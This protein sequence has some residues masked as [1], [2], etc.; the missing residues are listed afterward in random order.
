MVE[1][2]GRQLLSGR[3]WD[4]VITAWAVVTQVVFL[5]DAR[6]W[7]ESQKPV[8]HVVDHWDIWANLIRYEKSCHF[9]SNV[10]TTVRMYHRFFSQYVLMK[11]GTTSTFV[12]NTLFITFGH[13]W[14]GTYVRTYV[15]QFVGQP[16]ASNTQQKMS[17]AI[18]F[19]GYYQWLQV[20]HATKMLQTS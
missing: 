7:E 8:V 1:G 15:P 2:K 11:K 4:N 3:G 5:K 14:N 12:A 9:G 19:R 6:G 16:P 18:R 17:W 10:G 20:V 13:F